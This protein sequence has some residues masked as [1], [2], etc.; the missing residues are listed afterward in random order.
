M[1]AEYIV[2]AGNPNVILCERGIRTFETYTRNTMD[3]SAV[4]LLHQLTHLP[5]IVDPSHATGK[6]WLVPPLAMARCRGRAPTASWSRST[7]TRTQALSDGRAAAEPSTSSRDLMAELS[8]LH[9]HR[10]QPMIPGPQLRPRRRRRHRRPD[11]CL[12]DER[13]RRPTARG[14]RPARRPAAAACAASCACRG[15]KSI[16]HRA[17]LLAALAAGESR[18]HRRRRRPGRP[19]DRGDHAPRS[20][21]ASSASATTA[22]RSTTGSCSP[23]ADGARRAGR[24]ARLRQLRARRCAC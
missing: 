21:R 15:D 9:E 20:G 5:V 16:S 13:D 19:L 23:G 8:P 2:S 3:V 11:R 6:R 18:H 12:T 14:R 4:P 24:R 17:L 7:R 1:A 10:A 22:R